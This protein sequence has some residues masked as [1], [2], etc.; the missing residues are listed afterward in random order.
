M[1]NCNN[2]IARCKTR[3]IRAQ[4][5]IGHNNMVQFCTLH[6]IHVINSNKNAQ[7]CGTSDVQT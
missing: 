2:R 3:E 5:H 1:Q 7:I 6:D 4:S